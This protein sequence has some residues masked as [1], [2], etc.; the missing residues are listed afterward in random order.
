MHDVLASFRE[1]IKS[2]EES[3]GCDFPLVLGL[4]LIL[5][6]SIL[7]LGANI[8]SKGELVVGLLGLFV[9]NESEDLL[10]IDV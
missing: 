7:E 9:L 2:H 4:G 6:V 8:K 3:V 10:T 5:K 1:R